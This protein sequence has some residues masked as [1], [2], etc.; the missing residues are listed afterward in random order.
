MVQKEIWTAFEELRGAQIIGQNIN[1]SNVLR[2][3]TEKCG[4]AFLPD[5]RLFA[6]ENN[7]GQLTRWIAK[8]SER[9]EQQGE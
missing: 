9:I 6:A 1:N 7:T 4:T 3:L 2:L 5:G 8:E